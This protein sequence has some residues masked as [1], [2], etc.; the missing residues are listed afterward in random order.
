MNK[1]FSYFLILFLTLPLF[2]NEVVI[3][4]ETIGNGIEIKNHSKVTVHY[5]GKLEDNTEFDNS[6]KRNETFEFQIGSRQVI[7]GW[8]KGLLGMKEGGIR[9]IFIPY[10]LAYGENGAGEIIPPKSNLIFEIKIIKVEPPKYK[11]IDSYQLKLA[12]TDNDFE[13]LDIRNLDNINRTG[14]IPGSLIITAFDNN[15]NFLPD[16]ITKYQKLIKPTKKVIFVS[17]KGII[18]SILANGFVEQ[19]NQANI[20]HLKNGIEGLQSIKFKFDKN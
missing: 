5:I 7:L 14:K 19:L 12:M 18:S 6:Y 16:F 15:G 20:Y 11:T 8:E 4:E 13:I 10:Q 17:Q 9:K 2:A 3:L 1:F